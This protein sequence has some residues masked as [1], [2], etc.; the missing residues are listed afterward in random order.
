MA[1]WAANES[2]QEWLS[3]HLRPPVPS[4]YFQPRDLTL[5]SNEIVLLACMRNEVDR[6][7][8]FL[9]YY[10][11]LGVDRFL[12]VDNNSSDG[13]PELLAGEEDVEYFWTDTSYRGSAS[14]RL[15]LQE[16]ADAYATDHWVVTVDVDELLVF[17]GAEVLALKELCT[18]LANHDHAGLFTVMLDMYSDR[19]LRQTIYEPGTDYLDTCPYFETD[20]YEIAPGGSPPFIGV[21]GGPR[22]RLFRA[23]GE[24]GPRPMMKK[25]PLVRW[26]EGFSYIYSTHSHRYVPLSDTTGALLHFKFVDSF[27]RVAQADALRGD[28]RQSTHYRVYQ[29]R[30]EHDL[31]F[32]GNQSRRFQSPRDLVRLGV[33]RASTAFER[34]TAAQLSTSDAGT[35]VSQLLPAPVAPEGE[36]TIR[37]L[38]A[39]WPLVNNRQIARYFGSFQVPVQEQRAS[40]VYEMRQHIK[41]IDVQPDQVLVRVAEPAL[42]RWWHGTRLGLRVTVGRQTVATPTMDSGEAALEVEIESIEPGICRLPAAIGR[43]AS[44]EA[45]DRAPVMVSVHLVDAESATARESGGA[46]DPLPTQSS[47]GDD[48]LLY[49]QAWYPAGGS[50]TPE[51]GVRGTVDRLADGILRGWVYDAEQDTFD[52]AVCI[53][54]AGRLARYTWPN[55]RRV[56]LDRVRNAGSPIRGRGFAVELPLGFFGGNKEIPEIRIDAV[57]AGRNLVLRRSPLVLPVGARDAHWSEPAQVWCTATDGH[58]GAECL[59]AADGGRQTRPPRRPRWKVWS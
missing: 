59:L 55:E 17:P 8:Y 18:Y 54:I 33:M 13:T 28:R 58:S 20:T 51:H 2:E 23:N 47:R 44:Q 26:R 48:I 22:D 12:L 4:T 29:E 53:Y 37:S 25:I 11:R 38:A 9:E 43:A 30:V 42:H 6:L 16:L 52:V 35:S 56:D 19:P 15:W 57:V 14:G 36:L 7:P 32:Y 27:E 1:D 40:F 46:P 3:H 21:F 34:F 10:R 45:G 31:C 24:P 41:V 5:Q 39:I 50:A 49:H